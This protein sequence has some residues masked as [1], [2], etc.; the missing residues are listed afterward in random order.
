MKANDAGD[1]FPLWG[2]CLG[3]QFLSVCGAGGQNVLSP[4]DGEDY[5]IPLNL[6]DGMSYSHLF[7]TSDA[8]IGAMYERPYI[9]IFKKF[10]K[11]QATYRGETFVSFAFFNRLHSRVACW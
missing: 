6:S 8:K 1:V 7:H 10:S 4:V 11:V 3:F 5:T 2:T 9:N